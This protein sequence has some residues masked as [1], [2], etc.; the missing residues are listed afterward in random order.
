[1]VAAAK[2]DGTVTIYSSQGLDQLN[3]MAADFKAAYGVDVQ[4]VRG[5]D[6]DLAPKVEAEHQTGKGIDDVY[7]SAS[8]SWVQPKADAGGW[9]VAP[10]GPNLTG[11]GQYDAKQ[12][13]HP[14]NYFEVGSAVLTLGW[15]TD[16][17]KAGLA[18]Y[19]DLL[20]PSL[21][22]KI[23]VPE[24]TSPSIVDFYLWMNETYGADFSS[25]LAKQQ[26]HIYPSTLTIGQA[27]GSGEIGATP[28]AA[29]GQIIP[30][31]D[32]GSPVNF[33]ISDKGAWGARFFGMVLKTSPHP[34]AAQLL[35]DFLVTPQ[36]QADLNAGAG[37][38]LP[39]V[40]GAVIT[41]DKV[42]K[43]DLSQLTP[44]KVQA[45]QQQWNSEYR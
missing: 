13:S 18:D 23:G 9:F 38:V 12:F 35:A 33:K 30:A 26:P 44:E 16:Q 41:Q 29:P 37:A 4:V 22:G 11:Q 19:P 27:M 39:N 28:Y 7:V 40:P 1:M 25:K 24:P 34:D 21:K 6:G 15:N 10:T 5:V 32:K 8:L 45:F 2:K 20:N 31:K 36:A 3:K 17:A 43:Q 42:R 14:G